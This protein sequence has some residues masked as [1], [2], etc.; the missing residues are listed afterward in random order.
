[1]HH[2][3]PL[4]T[5]AAPLYVPVVNHTIVPSHSIVPSHYPSHSFFF[6]CGAEE[7]RQSSGDEKLH[8]AAQSVEAYSTSMLLGAPCL[9]SLEHLLL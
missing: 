3:A 5:S 7:G 4:C 9:A 1:M 6:C 8:R 2:C